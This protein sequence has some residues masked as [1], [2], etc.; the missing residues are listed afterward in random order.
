MSQ[1]FIYCFSNESYPGLLKI[2][3]TDRTPD[4]RL[5][6][7]N[8]CTWCHTPFINV[9]AKKVQNPIEKERKLHDYLKDKRVNPRREFFNI[10]IDEIR[11]LFALMDGE[12]WNPTKDELESP[13]DPI[14]PLELPTFAPNPQLEPKQEP[15]QE[16]AS[17]PVRDMAKCLKDGQRV[18]H[19]INKNVDD[20]HKTW[21]AIYNSKE[22][23]LMHNNIPY[24]T[25][26]GFAEAHY[27]STRKDRGSSVNG[28]TSCE[29]EINGE[30]IKLNAIQC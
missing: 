17:K 6:D 20:L 2:G 21:I 27:K 10:S 24:N 23:Q 15:K 13:P 12:I 18:R 25:P 16:P 22:N 14:S 7:A 11:K 5:K 19:I 1:G 4:D 28:W 9:I 29:C 26:S 3:M 30:W 8:S